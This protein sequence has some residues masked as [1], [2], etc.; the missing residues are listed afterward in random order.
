MIHPYYF[1]KIC[2]LGTYV[3][4]KQYINVITSAY[5]KITSR[6]LGTLCTDFYYKIVYKKVQKVHWQCLNFTLNALCNR[7]IYR[8]LIR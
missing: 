4:I 7:Y 8:R 5:L 6:T 3:Y 1:Y 2:T